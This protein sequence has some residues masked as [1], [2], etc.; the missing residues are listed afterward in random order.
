MSTFY[1]EILTTPQTNI[2]KHEL[3]MELLICTL[4]VG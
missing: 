1:K 3:K 4:Q 2:Q